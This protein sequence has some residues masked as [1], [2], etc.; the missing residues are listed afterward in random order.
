MTNV[1]QLAMQ[2]EL[3]ESARERLAAELIR[4]RRIEQ[5]LRSHHR[6]LP[7]QVQTALREPARIV[8][9]DPPPLGAPDLLANCR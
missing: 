6:R 5:V 1:E 9:M 4:L 2:M 3:G 7:H 8:E